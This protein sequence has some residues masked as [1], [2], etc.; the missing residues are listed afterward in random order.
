MFY[1]VF[2]P[3]NLF[4][5]R[6]MYPVCPV[7]V[8]LI[9]F[10]LVVSSSKRSSSGSST[11]RLFFSKTGSSRAAA[12]A[13]A[14]FV[15]LCTSPAL[16]W[17]CLSLSLSL[18]LSLYLTTEELKTSSKITINLCLDFA[19]HRFYHLFV[20]FNRKQLPQERKGDLNTP[21]L[22]LLDLHVCKTNILRH[23]PMHISIDLSSTEEIR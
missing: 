15:H 3:K 4:S 10:F 16:L 9:F 19:I 6:K 18:S 1:F 2:L 23:L 13:A 5:N 20:S 12:A 7:L 21:L 8:P 11:R 14:A 22:D 17:F